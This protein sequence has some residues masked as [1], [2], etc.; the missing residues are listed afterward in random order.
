[1]GL[2]KSYEANQ[3]SNSYLSD[4]KKCNK[5]YKGQYLTVYGP[6]WQSYTNKFNEKIIILMQKDGK[7]GVK[8]ILS[9]TA[10]QMDRPLKQGETLT[11]NGK[12]VGFDE[13][14]VLEGC[15]ILGGK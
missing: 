9:S 2:D 3:L 11:I 15:F 5:V 6:V 12:C 13:H 1:M 14:V 4:T 8:C 7:A 10:K